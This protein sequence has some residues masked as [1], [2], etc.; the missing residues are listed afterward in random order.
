MIVPAAV[1]ALFAQSSLTYGAA[2]RQSLG[3]SLRVG[4]PILPVAA[5][6]FYIRTYVLEPAM[7]DIAKGNPD[8]ALQRLD[9]WYVPGEWLTTS[10]YS[11]AGGWV[12]DTVGSLF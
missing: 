4:L 3:G 10:W 9:A 7:Q 5:Y 2:F 8:A 1:D 6:D 12:T 11:Q